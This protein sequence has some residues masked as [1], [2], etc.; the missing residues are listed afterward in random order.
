VDWYHARVPLAQAANFIHGKGT[1][2]AHQWLKDQETV[3]FEGHVERVADCLIGL[4]KGRRTVSAELRWQAGYFRDNQRRTQ[5]LE[6]REEGF[7][8]GSGLAES[9]CKQFRAR[10]TGPGMRWS[11]PGAERLLPVRAA[12]T[13]A[14]T[15]GAV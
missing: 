15:A 6:Q 12:I 3:L 11:R 8:I 1:L 5:Y 7:P 9:G 13:P 14:P 4:A 2:A 10:L